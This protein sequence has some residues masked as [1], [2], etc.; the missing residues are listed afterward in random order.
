[1]FDDVVMVI[2]SVESTPSQ[3]SFGWSTNPIC[4]PIAELSGLHQE[5]SA[6]TNKPSQKVQRVV[7]SLLTT[8]DNK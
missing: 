5:V 1:V 7:F 8:H 2:P 6:T 3:S 4:L